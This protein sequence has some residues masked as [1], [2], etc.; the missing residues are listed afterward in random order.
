MSNHSGDLLEV[1][2]FPESEEFCGESHQARPAKFGV[3]VLSRAVTS[4]FL[5]VSTSCF[6]CWLAESTLFSN[7][8]KFANS[9]DEPPALVADATWLPAGNV[10][11]GTLGS[12]KGKRQLY[13]PRS[14][15]PIVLPTESLTARHDVKK[16]QNFE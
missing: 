16:T 12:R 13:N 2:Q 7:S 11:Q 5:I 6:A 8:A 1:N 10:A 3:P 14:N 4:F 9:A 15:W